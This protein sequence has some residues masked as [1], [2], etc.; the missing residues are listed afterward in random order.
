M[1]SYG[2]RN[3]ADL[4]TQWCNSPPDGTP[5]DSC[6]VGDPVY[7][8]TG[9]TTIAETDF[10]SGDDVPLA[11]RRTYRAQPMTRNDAGVGS[12]WVHN[13]Q[14]KLG[15]ANAASSN[16]QV[17]AYRADGNRITF[18][19]VA[20]AWR[21]AGFSG[22]ALAQ[23][24]SAWTLSDLAAGIVETYSSQGTLLSV[25]MSNRRMI[26]LTYSDAATPLTIAPASGL[27]ISVTQHAI[28]YPVFFDVTIRLAYDKKWRLSQM[29]DPTG[30][31]TQY[32]YD[33]LNNL[34]SVTW[35]DGNVRRYL[36]EDLRFGGAL[37]GLIDE[38][39]TR[40]STWTYDSKGRA[41]GVSHPDASRNVQLFYGNGTSTVSDA[42]GSNTLNYSWLGN[43][44]RNVTG[45]SPTGAN[46]STYDTSGNLLT[47]NN[48]AGGAEYVYDDVA[49]PVRA[50]VHGASGTTVTSVR[51]ADAST[52]RPY[53]IASPG[54]MRAFVYDAQGNT[55]GISDLPTDDPTGEQG[56]DA[57]TA[58][59][60]QV[61]YGAVY[62][63]GNNLAYLEMYQ[64]GV[65][66]GAWLVT[67]G[68]TGNLRS[69]GNRFPSQG[70]PLQPMVTARDAANR[71]VGL[72]VNDFA[73]GVVYDGRG[74]VTNF[75][76]YATPKPESGNVKRR[77]SIAYGYGPTGKVISRVGT[78]ETNDDGGLPISNDEIDRWLNNYENGVSPIVPSPALV[79]I[80]KGAGSQTEI[81]PVC[82]ECYFNAGGWPAVG[83]DP[84][85]F[86]NSRT[87][88]LTGGGPVDIMSAPPLQGPAAYSSFDAID[89]GGMIKCN[90]N[91]CAEE[92]A[93]CR[94]TCARAAGD[95]NQTHV[96]T[97]KFAT[98]MRSCIP[99][100]CGGF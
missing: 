64:D 52:L 22:L 58:N 76:L 83:P 26:T 69:V 67:Y 86:Y 18:N 39:G 33:S 7:P 37:T 55:T 2:C 74:R 50:V 60:P 47:Q 38:S 73:T 90:D 10:I 46:T 72:S 15:L 27:L 6:P 88:K 40:V 53:M 9:S 75:S 87:G 68:P 97:G 44:L 94:V 42:T 59:G 51:Y 63:S 13:W 14:M 45:S 95:F 16:A 5:E 71:P 4:I 48:P 92:K 79:G 3:N 31:V 34:V 84:R 81:R 19:K 23:T 20:G 93:A 62:E 11:F 41:T 43:M 35:P 56:F 29:T 70:Q 98:C 17:F 85:A 24:G 32:A 77:L 36:Y 66:T 21:T 100:R 99:A 25:N 12:L 54:R 57:H 78:L 30:A 96:W 1:G 80:V 89:G 8:A 91:G 61:T 49:R 65:L 82:V 28:G